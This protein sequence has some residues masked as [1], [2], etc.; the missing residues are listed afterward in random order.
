MEWTGADGTRREESWHVLG[1]RFALVAAR[2]A[3]RD[4]VDKPPEG[5][6]LANE[7]YHYWP[8]RAVQARLV[9]RREGLRSDYVLCGEGWCLPLERL[10]PRARAPIVEITT[11][12]TTR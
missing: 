11:C 1:D 7:W 6:V 8:E 10:L 2:A 4:G 5:A 9:L 12:P 3:R